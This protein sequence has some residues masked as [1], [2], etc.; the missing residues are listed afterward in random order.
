MSTMA[1]PGYRPSASRAKTITKYIKNDSH[2]QFPEQYREPFSNSGEVIKN[3]LD[4]TP[5]YN[6][7]KFW[8][9]QT[10]DGAAIRRHFYFLERFIIR[11]KTST[12]RG[13]QLGRGYRSLVKKRVKFIVLH[14]SPPAS[15]YSKKRTE[16]TIKQRL[17]N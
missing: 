16:I 7:K 9:R 13:F 3:S 8:D 5:L 10:G 11:D 1:L 14:H 2:A 4:S 17:I 12:S 15:S 6:V